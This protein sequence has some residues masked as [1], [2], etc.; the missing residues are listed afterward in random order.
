MIERNYPEIK[1]CGLT[2][3]DEAKACTDLGADAIGLVFY[4]RSPRNVTIAQAA[5]IKAALPSCVPAVGV[6]VD[7]DLETLLHTVAD[8]GLD[9]IQLHGAESPDFT[10][11]LGHATDAKIIKVLFATKAPGLNDADTY[12]VSGFLVECGQGPLPG[13]NAMAWDWGIA[14][15]FA[16]RNPLILAGGLGPDTVSSAV[17]ACLPDAVDAS[18]ALEALPG[19]KDLSKVEQFIQAVQNSAIHYAAGSRR[20]RPIFSSCKN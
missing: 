4:P 1:V 17:S 13:G 20:L 5:A 10:I 8:C 6:F 15:P 2:R 12:D 3:P 11:Q 18:S 7:P 19:R 16:Q 9:V 14:K